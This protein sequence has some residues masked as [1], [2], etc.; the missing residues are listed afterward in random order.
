MPGQ[1]Q[2]PQPEMEAAVEET[3]EV[4]RV[5]GSV[6]A[7]ATKEVAVKEVAI[8]VEVEAVAVTEVG[9]MVG[10]MAAAEEEDYMYT[11]HA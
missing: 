4:E 10:E 7:V 11:M 5:V 6:T 1:N 2:I 3:E 9:E 8:M